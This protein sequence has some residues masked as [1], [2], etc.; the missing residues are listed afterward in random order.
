MKKQMIAIA[1]AA[2]FAAPAFAG[3]FEEPM[4]DT[5]PEKAKVV[6]LSQ[7]EMRETEGAFTINQ[8]VVATHSIGA[9][10]GMYTGGYAYLLAGGKDPNGFLGSAA[11]GFVGGAIA[12]ATGIKGGITAAIATVANAYTNA[13]VSRLAEAGL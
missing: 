8:T 4:F 13:T 10:S 3:G 7:K 2:S 5:Q 6:E 12:P 1:L 9:L 11:G